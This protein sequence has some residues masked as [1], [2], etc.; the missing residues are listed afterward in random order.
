MIWINKN[1]IVAFKYNVIIEINFM[2][3]NR[4]SVRN[5]YGRNV[6]K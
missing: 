1:T 2:Y 3:E 6:K 5:Y 4:N